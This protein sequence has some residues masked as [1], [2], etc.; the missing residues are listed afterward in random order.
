MAAIASF[1]NMISIQASDAGLKL[2][3]NEGKYW[4]CPL[5]FRNSI[6]ASQ[7]V[8]YI[9]SSRHCK[10]VGHAQRAVQFREENLPPFFFELNEDFP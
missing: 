8:N 9:N 1:W 7:I 10:M 3:V 4:Q 2:E 6:E 5:C